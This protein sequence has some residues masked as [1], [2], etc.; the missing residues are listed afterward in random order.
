M[1]PVAL[2]IANM[3]VGN[4]RWVEGLEVTLAGPTLKFLGP[5][6]VSLTGAPIE[7]FLDDSPFPM[8]SRKHIK[9]GQTLTVGKTTAG[10]C[11]SYIAVHGG[12]SNVASYFGS[13]STSPIVAIGGYQG[14]QLAPG[15]QLSL[16]KEIPKSLSGHP[17]LPDHLRP[18]Y[19]SKWEI[20]AL[21]GPHE[22][23][24]LTD[25][26]IEMLY[27]TEWKVSHN[28]SRSAIRLVGPV[29]EW[30][31][32]DGGEG[33][34]HPSNVV[35]YGYSIGSL[36][37]T[38]DEGCIFG[39]DCPNFG[40]FASSATAIKAD[41]WKLGQLKAGATLVYK[42]VSL[43]EALALRSK[44]SVYLNAVEHAVLQGDFTAVP[45]FQSTYEP[46]GTYS[47]AVIWTREPTNGNP[48]VRYRQA[49]DD[50]I[51]VE[52]GNEQFDL[53]YRC[54][55]TAL[56]KAL[57]GPDAPS[58]LKDHL[59]NTI[60]C[61]TS[62]TICYDGAKLPRDKLIKHL[63]T[64][65]DQIGDLSTAKVPCRRFNL[66]LSFESKE[67]TEATKRYMETLRPQAPYLPD[68]LGFVARNNAFT[69]DK[70]K[71]NMLNGELMA[72]AVG[73]F[74]G[75]TVS[76][77][78]DP[79]QRMSCPKANPSRTFTPEGTFGWGGS[80]A[81]IY[82]VDSP[83]GYQ[84]LGRTIPCFDYYGFKA[85]FT[86]ER[87]WIFQDF[88]LLTFY[89]VSEDELDK[90]LELFRSGQY[91][92]EWEEVEFDMAEHNK[93]LEDTAGEV[94]QI[95]AAQ[96]EV[97]LA[98][99]KAENESLEKWRADKAKNKVDDQTI[100]SILEDPDIEA[101]E[102]PVDA[103]VWRVEVNQG[104]EVKP[105]QIVVILEAM[106]LEI[107]INVPES[108]A[109]KGRAVVE[110]VLVEPGETIK[111]SNIETEERI[112]VLMLVTRR[113]VV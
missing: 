106:K 102:S 57:H 99:I 44:L 104:D 28:A 2:S 76:L 48:Q 73:F 63:Q 111:V 18:Q 20:M 89:R 105:N 3:L 103:N 92:F 50:Y 22:E 26:D 87:P 49:G 40:G 82:P 95:R 86:P 46:Q 12:F 113:A 78:V 24:Y 43:D 13:K 54:R 17:V 8:W 72:V 25:A 97:Q 62:I 1:D 66:P 27:S 15:D 42:R 81:S 10:G 47:K 33:G 53:N 85:G 98:M 51:L 32:S 79:R 19:E 75:N 80:C 88:D 59:T 4:E 31:R 30:A 39:F 101:I 108:L 34:S 67:Q 9:A 23:G 69:S 68:N 58:W 41:H 55:A 71:H 56:E 38:G 60:S 36:N 84:M 5:A 52:Y 74:C 29:P 14:R 45:R 21:P 64:L 109:G 37:W 96:A 6:V 70:L 83:G 7:A 11:R 112:S 61:C 107:N 94:K 16:V 91:K 35:E 93:L 110:K 77:P 90:Q 100:D 65:E